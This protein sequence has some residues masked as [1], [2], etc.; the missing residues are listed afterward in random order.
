MSL[1]IELLPVMLISAR[2]ARK[3]PQTPASSSKEPPPPA[4]TA[5][6]VIG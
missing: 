4:A 5:A 6:V 1:L 2:N 3:R